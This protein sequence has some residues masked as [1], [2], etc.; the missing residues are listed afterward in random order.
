MKKIKALVAQIDALNS[1]VSRLQAEHDSLP[2]GPNMDRALSARGRQIS[3]DARSISKTID[4]LRADIVS[5]AMEA[6]SVTREA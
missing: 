3:R 4:L 5:A 6:Y 1:Q 2:W